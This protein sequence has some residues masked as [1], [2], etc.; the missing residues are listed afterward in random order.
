LHRRGAIAAGFGWTKY[1]FQLGIALIPLSLLLHYG[2][3]LHQWIAMQSEPWTRVGL[4]A[5][6]VLGA[7]VVYFIAL[8]VVGI[9]WQH[10]RRHAK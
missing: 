3:N 8:W 1:L 5:A 2:A 6:W 9:R 4:L 10:F 7:A